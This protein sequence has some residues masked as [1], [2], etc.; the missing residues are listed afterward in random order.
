[1]FVSFFFVYV[2]SNIQARYLVH[3]DVDLMDS[4]ALSC[5]LY[6]Y[7]PF[8]KSTHFDKLY[9]EPSTPEQC[10][11]NALIFVDAVK[12]IGLSYDVQPI[13]IL[14]PNPI[15]M[16]LFC[17]Y[18]YSTLSTYKAVDNITFSTALGKTSEAKV[19]LL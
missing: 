7:C 3:F 12:T 5:V 4:M 16:I 18:L 8:L 11:H 13:D 15:F 19:K 2:D 9:M 6:S 10:A 14:S 17:A 1:M